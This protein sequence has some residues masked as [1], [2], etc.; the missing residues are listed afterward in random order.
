[1][2]DF[3]GGLSGVDDYLNRTVSI[4]TSATVDP[5][6]G[7]VTTTESSFTMRELICSLLA[8]NG[9]KL[10]NLQICLKANLGRLLNN[11]GVNWQ[12]ALGDLYTALSEAEQAL[13]DFTA[14]TDIENVLGRLNGAIAE[15]A[16]VANM[17]NFCGTPI[18]P[19]A[20]PNVLSDMFGSF[21]GQGKQLLDSLGTMADSDIG[22]CINSDGSFNPIFNGGVLKDI[23]D[24]LSNLANLPQS[25]LD[26]FTNTLK[27]FKN[28]I[29]NLITFENNFGTGSTDTGGKGGSNFA[30][31]TRVHTGIGVGIDPNNI[32]LQQ[33]QGIANNLKS[34]YDALKSY[35][36]DGAGNNIF[37]YLLE[38]ELI[39]KL[40]EQNNPIAT[41][42]EQTPVYDYCG[43]VIGYTNNVTQGN[44]QTS[45]GTSAS[46]PVQ[47][48]IQ[49]LSQS[50]QKIHNQPVAT[51]N[52]A[53][54]AAGSTGTSSGGGS[55]ASVSGVNTA[56][57]SLNPSLTFS[58]TSGTLTYTPPDLSQ[59]TTT[60]NLAPV[61]L[62]GDYYALNNRPSNTVPTVVSAFTNDVGYITSAN[63]P[64]NISVF[65]NDSGYITNTPVNAVQANLNSTNSKLNTIVAQ[66]NTYHNSAIARL[67]TTKASF[68]ALLP[69]GDANLDS[70][71]NDLI[72]DINGMISEAQAAIITQTF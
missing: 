66:V 8:G 18:V 67:N 62:S 34:N 51:T 28:D 42:G 70:A 65:T 39:A 69:T 35:E 63:I 48:G 56:N 21:T 47:P 64:T 22:G 16:A 2:A 45:L 23:Q 53:N 68:Q 4:P 25:T 14:H 24:N 37:H 26:N 13:E 7:V 57:A 46:I 32:T 54:T 9:L 36:V 61:A 52:L 50:G 59:Y 33:A 11:A 38:P 55:S 12:G 1:M 3:P 43:K 10:P 27:A 72:T 6:T 20:I 71:I 40:D 41:V 30:P 5:T 31:T 49:G 15:F 44:T 58:S 19:R 29:D 60:A 17:I